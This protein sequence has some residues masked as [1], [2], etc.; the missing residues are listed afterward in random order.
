MS[1]AIAAGAVA[2]L[3][4]MTLASP[5]DAQ[6]FASRDLT[7]MAGQLSQALGA[8]TQARTAPQRLTLTCDTC[9]GAPVVDVMIGRQTD[10]TEQRVRSGE[11][12]I[13]ELEKL[14]QARSPGCRMSALQ[15]APAVGWVS[16]YP[17]GAQQG[18][19]AVIMRDG[20][21]LVVRAV[22]ADASVARRTCEKM[23]AALGPVIG[24]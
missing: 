2:L 14:C 16:S 11:T 13:A 1:P 20:D 6:G 19:T 22:S 4:L 12:T 7:G 17:M 23:V 15:V 3:A 10:G 5:A 8:G 18:S 21:M 9:A 24:R